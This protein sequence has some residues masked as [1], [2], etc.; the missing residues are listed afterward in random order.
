MSDAE[1]LIVKIT[2]ATFRGI[3]YQHKIGIRVEVFAI[4]KMA[5]KCGA[6]AKYPFYEV[7]H[8]TADRKYGIY[9]RDCDYSAQKSRSIRTIRTL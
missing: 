6:K 4:P 5:T 7:V 8:P 9:C 2:G 1:T 3:W